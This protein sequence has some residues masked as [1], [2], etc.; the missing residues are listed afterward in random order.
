MDYFSL[1]RGLIFVVI[2]TRVS[3]IF[4]SAIVDS[5]DDEDDHDDND[6]N[7]EGD[8][9]AQPCWKKRAIT[10]HQTRETPFTGNTL[11][12]LTI[13]LT[14]KDSVGLSSALK[15]GASIQR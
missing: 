8:D 9:N 13:R 6:K 14:G 12:I 7:R 5:I 1:V 10:Q 11:E 4:T 3:I 2:N 15:L